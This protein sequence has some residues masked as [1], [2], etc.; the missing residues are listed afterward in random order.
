MNLILLIKNTVREFLED[1][2]PRLAAALSYYAVMSLAP[3]L[4]L[5]LWLVGLVF[6]REEAQQGLLEQV[7][8]LAGP[9][10]AGA[11]EG[12][13]SSTQDPDTSGIVASV[14]SLGVLLFGA[15]GVFIQ[16]QDSLNT[17]WDVQPKPGR[18]IG[19][20][21]KSRFLSFSMVLGIGFFCCWSLVLSAALSAAGAFFADLIPGGPTLWQVVNNLVSVAV[22]ALLFG[23]MFKVLPDAEI[24][25]RD[26]W[27][28]AIVT[29]LLFNFGKY[30]IGLY[31]GQSGAASSYGAAGSLVIILL[32]VYYSALILFFGAEF[33]QVWARRHGEVI[34][35]APNAELVL[36]KRELEGGPR[37]APRPPVQPVLEPGEREFGSSLAYPASQAVR[38]SRSTGGP[39]SIPVTGPEPPPAVR[40]LP[41]IML[42]AVAAGYG[43][44]ET[45]R[46]AVR[47]IRRR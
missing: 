22:I 44:F 33:T 10:A 25:W 12:I 14:I 29:S 9:S 3:L 46:A 43:L 2:A 15:S 45:G 18:G 6:S 39:A 42:G 21:I 35:P 38:V 5:I 8:S 41:V 32:W 20:V 24:R 40:T 47:R 7:T 28:G 16:L 26:V 31:L 13:I 30:L 11:V 17:V 36:D 1:K 34:Q 4:I 23:L 27:V 37:P 19:E